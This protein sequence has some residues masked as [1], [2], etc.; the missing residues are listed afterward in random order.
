MYHRKRGAK[1]CPNSILIRQEKLDAVVLDAIADALD[2]RLIERAVEEAAA[3]SARRRKAVP[4]R[5]TQLEQELTEVEARL[6]RAN[7]ALLGEKRILHELR[8]HVR[9]VRQLLG[10]DVT[11]TRQI[12]RK[13]LVGRLECHAFSEVGRVGY[14]FVGQGSYAELLPEKPSTLVV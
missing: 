1:V 14:R 7:S 11:R 9:D 13:L 5:R 8:A 3:I 10:Q 6:Q 12:L 2:E 4:D